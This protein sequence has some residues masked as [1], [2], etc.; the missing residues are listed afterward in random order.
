MLINCSKLVQVCEISSIPLSNI[1]HGF[2]S[3]FMPCWFVHLVGRRRFSPWI[4]F[5]LRVLLSAV[6]PRTSSCSI[7]FVSWRI[8]G[9]SQIV[10]WVFFGLLRFIIV[11]PNNWVQI[12]VPIWTDYLTIIDYSGSNLII[13]NQIIVVPDLLVDFYIK[14]EN[15]TRLSS[16]QKSRIDGVQHGGV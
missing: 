10:S 1:A 5:W 7:L 14:L 4:K 11:C 12:V 16:Q 9:I 15:D 6:I 2:S 13:V 3:R 8:F